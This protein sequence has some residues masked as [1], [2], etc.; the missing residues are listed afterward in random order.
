MP[1][2]PSLSPRALFSKGIWQQ[3]QGGSRNAPRMDDVRRGS[4]HHLGWELGLRE[5][6]PSAATGISLQEYLDFIQVL[7]LKSVKPN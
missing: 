2:Q 3:R 7:L 4:W 6:N 1:T 5:E